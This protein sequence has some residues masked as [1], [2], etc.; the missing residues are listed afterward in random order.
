V[1]T[2]Y[3]DFSW[4]GIDADGEKISGEITAENKTVAKAIL[5]KRGLVL[6]ALTPIR[7]KFSLISMQRL[8][9]KQ[10][11]DFTQQI[12]LLLQSGIPLADTLV[13]IQTSSDNKMIC[14]LCATLKEKIASGVSFSIALRHFPHYFDDTFCQ[15]I[16]AGEE[17][18]QLEA[19]LSQLV[20]DQAQRHLMRRKISKILFYP[21]SVLCIAI[22]IAIGLLIF[23]IPQFASIYRNFNAQLPEM[24]R[25]M[26]HLSLIL[27]H[28]SMLILICALAIIFLFKQCKSFT[29]RLTY[30]INYIFFRFPPIRALSMSKHVARWSQLLSITLFSGIALIDAL[31]IANHAISQPALKIQ[32]SLVRESVIKGKSLR[33]S[34][35]HC[36]YFPMRAKSMIAIGENADALGE[37]L[38]KIAIVYQQQWD[39]S[40]DRLSKL[41]EPVIMIIVASFVSSLIVAMYLPI[42][43]MGNAI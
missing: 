36:H 4:T 10:Q 31:S 14:T 29:A 6:L 33:L 39:D 3:I 42:F 32:M 17:T 16:A 38:K 22:I 7:K 34:L 1:Q 41:L 12:L 20:S 2:R 30:H 19:V 40:L 21:I 13:L 25:A 23:V 18:G 9:K 11:V 27:H 43:K 26:I 5:E 35:D 28:D 24:T 15:M 8:T 37:M